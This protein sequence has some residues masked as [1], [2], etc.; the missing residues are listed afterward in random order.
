MQGSYNG[1][2]HNTNNG[3][4]D[5]VNNNG[6]NNGDQNNEG[7][8]TDFMNDMNMD[9]NHMDMMMPVGDRLNTIKRQVSMR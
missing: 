9:K 5:F 3:G 6:Q 1:D 8:S 4:Q 7:Q 2:S